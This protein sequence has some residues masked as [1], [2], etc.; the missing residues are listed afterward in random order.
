MECPF[1]FADQ[2]DDKP[3]LRKCWRYQRGNEKLK[4]IEGQTIKW[5]KGRERTNKSL[6]NNTHKTKDWATT[7]PNK[8]QGYTHVI[9]KGK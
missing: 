3:V 7:N 5:P 9:R 4:I 8:N 1:L 6:W 2:K